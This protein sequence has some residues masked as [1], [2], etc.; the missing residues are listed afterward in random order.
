MY[1]KLMHIM[2]GIAALMMAATAQAALQTETIQY[3]VDG[4]PFTGYLAYDD[5]LQG[6]RPGVLVVHEWW[7]HNEFARRQAEELARAGYTGMALDMYGA[8]KLADHPDD[9]Q[10]FMQEAISDPEAMEARFRQA[11]ATLQ[12]HES[13]DG[14][15][16]AAQG[17]C[18]GGAVVLNMARMGLDLAGVV[19]FHGS[20]GATAPAE[21]GAVRARIQVYTGGADP[22]VPA[23]Q[24]TGFVEEMLAAGADVTVRSF[25]GAVHG[26]MNPDADEFGERFDMPLA[27]DEDAAARAWAGTLAFYR[28]LFEQ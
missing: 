27:Y 14:G 4:E 15:R 3:E 25:P 26:F 1:Q 2:L 8:G 5:A 11:M 21:P 18:F 16:I 24:V 7:G 13:V 20:L 10:A 19:S 9:A 6:E 23:E 22:F 17:Y 12:A 28:E